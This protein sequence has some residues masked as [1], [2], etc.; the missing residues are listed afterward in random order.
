MSREAMQQLLAA[1]NKMAA[2]INTA[3]TAPVDEWPTTDE[4]DAAIEQ[5]KK[6]TATDK[7]SLT[8]AD[9]PVALEI[10]D[11][12]TT[13]YGTDEGWLSRDGH[14]FVCGYSVGKLNR[15][16]PAREWVG[17]TDEEIDTWNIVGHESLR[18]FVRAIEAKLKEKN[19]GKDTPDT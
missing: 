19:S 9:E 6:A 13:L 3:I 8:V 5:W 10:K 4:L 14:F 7:E 1:G 18:E 2:I 17:L 12:W 16:Q 15:P 11:A